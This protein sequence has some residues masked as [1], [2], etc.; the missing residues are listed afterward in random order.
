MH[1]E[2]SLSGSALS[3]VGLTLTWDTE[4]MWSNGA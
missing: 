4:S 3:K 1:Q 2:D